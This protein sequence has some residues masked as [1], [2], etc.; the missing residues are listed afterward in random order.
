MYA[1]NCSG[2]PPVVIAP[3]PAYF[4]RIAALCSALLVAALSLSITSRGVPAG[5][6]R[7]VT[8]IGPKAAKPTS[9]AVGTSGSIG[10]RLSDVTSSARS[11]P[12]CTWL[13]AEVTWSKCMSTWPPMRSEIAGL[14]PL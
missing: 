5:A 13:P 8:L 3:T 11:L 9:A 10:A 2:V 12:A 7:P 14:L 6:M 4:S 1:A